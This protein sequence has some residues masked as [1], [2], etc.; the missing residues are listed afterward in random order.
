MIRDLLK[1]LDQN[2][3]VMVNKHINTGTSE[4]LGNKANRICRFCGETRPKVNFKQTTHAIPEFTGNTNLF[5]YYE[6]S[7]CNQDFSIAE[8]NMAEYMKLYHTMCQVPGKRGVPSFKPNMQQQSRID[9]GKT[10]MEIKSY[11]GDDFSFDMNEEKQSITIR[12]TRNYVPALVF[13]CLTKM[14]MSIMPEEEVINF[15]KTLK[16]LRTDK[17]IPMQ[18]YSYFTMYSG[19][20]PFGW[21][22]CSIFKRKDNHIDNVPYAVFLLAYSNFVFQ[23]PVLFCEKDKELSKA[24]MSAIPT[25]LDFESNILKRQLIDFSSEEKI[26]KE[27]VEI[28]MNFGKLKEIDLSSEEEIQ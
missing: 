13:K 2:Y 18:L 4:Y 3:I 5:T 19:I 7:T 16:W 25:P 17:K 24:T 9:K 11:E 14:A 21:V 26:S 23:I 22:T 12:G 8:S 6:C 28:T 10:A 27:P 20:Y 15:E 1:K